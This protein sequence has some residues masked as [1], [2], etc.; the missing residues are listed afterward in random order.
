MNSLWNV[1]FCGRHHEEC[2]PY[3]ACG[4]SCLYFLLVYVCVILARSMSIHL[5]IRCCATHILNNSVL[6]RTGHFKTNFK[7]SPLHSQPG[8]GPLHLLHM[9]M[10]GMLCYSVTSYNQYCVNHSE[11]GLFATVTTPAR[12]DLYNIV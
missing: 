7:Y 1:T 6:C 5:Y 11:D 10:W 3:I 12:V 9:K 4:V 8:K 2:F